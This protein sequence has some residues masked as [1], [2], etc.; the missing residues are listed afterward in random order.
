MA[1]ISRGCRIISANGRASVWLK[2]SLLCG[3][4]TKLMMA[5]AYNR[6]PCDGGEVAGEH[7]GFEIGPADNHNHRPE[8]RR[9]YAPK[10]NP[11]NCLRLEQ[12]RGSIGSGKPIVA[13][14][15]LIA[16]LQKRAERETART[17]ARISHRPQTSA[18]TK[19]NMAPVRNPTLRPTRRDEQG[20]RHSG[21]CRSDHK[22]GNRQGCQAQRGGQLCPQRGLQ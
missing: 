14:E 21:Q 1:T 4:L 20:S 11:G 12:C 6:Q 22:G 19:P 10:H 5:I 18:P 15:S 8:D 2:S 13:G 3:M 9:S 16:A 17:A 7:D